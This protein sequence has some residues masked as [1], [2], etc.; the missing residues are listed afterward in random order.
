MLTADVAAGAAGD[1]AAA[2]PLASCLDV[3]SHP[4]THAHAVGV[5]EPTVKCYNVDHHKK[6]KNLM[7]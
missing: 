4:H 5:H 1:A 3:S 6:C 7:K 2:A